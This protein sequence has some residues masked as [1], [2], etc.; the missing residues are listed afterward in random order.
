ML[1]TEIALDDV[2]GSM[3]R[4]LVEVR[5]LKA[6]LAIDREIAP[7]PLTFG[8]TPAMVYKSLGDASFLLDGLRGGSMTT[9]DVYRNAAVVLAEV[10]LVARFLGVAVEGEP[11]AAG[12]AVSALEAPRV[13]TEAV[14]RAL[15]ANRKAIDLQGRLAMS[16]SRDPGLSLVRVTLSEAYDV[17]NTLLAELAR[18]K[19]H[20]GID[21][22]PGEDPEP[23]D[24]R[25]ADLLA[26]LAR[27]AA[28]LDRVNGGVTPELSIRLMEKHEALERE[29]L[30][31]EARRQR[32]AEA[33][34][35]LELERRRRAEAE[36][37]AALDRLREMEAERALE[38][39]RMRQSEAE[40]DQERAR[41]RQAEEQLR[42]LEAQARQEA[43]PAP[44]DEDAAAG[45]V[46]RPTGGARVGALPHP[47]RPQRE[48]PDPE[49]PETRP[50]RL[51]KCGH[52][53][54]L[55]RRRGR[56]DGGRGS[57]SGAGTV[58]GGSTGPF[59]PLRASGDQAGAG[60]VRRV[61]EPGGTVVQHGATGVDHR[62]F[63]LLTRGRQRTP[64][65]RGAR[66]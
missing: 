31:Q 26:L 32:Q 55:C 42:R 64:G 3:A 29:R 21:A 39:E 24:T 66:R 28:N 10:A 38:L 48:R 14:R 63:R 18:V 62:S 13:V 27:I 59:R 12:R 34:R 60:M 2:L 61:P 6:H 54:A 50:D 15:A 56:R 57:G 37:Q 44:G 33:E 51:R 20:L 5:R 45:P 7:A 49:L 9:T 53:A 46:G 16:P 17:T 43:G 22:V 35:A 58:Q 41:L 4:L 30:E 1:A 36:R 23:T 65:R 8:S 25:L 40:L 11:A 19:F 52:H 47:V